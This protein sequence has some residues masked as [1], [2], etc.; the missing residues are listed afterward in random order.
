SS[1][2]WQQQQVIE[3]R[4][5]KGEIKLLY[6]APERLLMP[7]NLDLLDSI[8]I[9]LFAID[10]AHCVSQWGHDFRQDYLGLGLLKQR[11]PAVPVIALTA[12]ADS[13]TREDIIGN[14]QLRSPER[15]IGGFDRPN[16]RYTVAPK[17]DARR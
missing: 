6:M 1:V 2:E 10:E 5:R 16:I 14:L 15:L 3:A 8:D 11:F 17:Q 7:G 13:R 12:T 9:S 4:L